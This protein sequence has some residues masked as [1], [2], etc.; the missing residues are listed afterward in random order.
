MSKWPR[1]FHTNT[2]GSTE[3]G[4][5]T[6]RGYVEG[7]WS[8]NLYHLLSLYLLAEFQTVMDGFGWNIHEWLAKSKPM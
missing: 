2:S 8:D 3:K 7:N 4:Q 6:R 5:F 1:S